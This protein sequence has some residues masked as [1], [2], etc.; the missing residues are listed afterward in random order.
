MRLVLMMLVAVAVCGCHGV[1]V[2]AT[3]L[4]SMACS[5]DRPCHPEQGT[6]P[7]AC[8][9]DKHDQCWCPK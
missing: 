4:S 5:S 3:A 1:R 7:P 2:N 8:K 6:C 9:L